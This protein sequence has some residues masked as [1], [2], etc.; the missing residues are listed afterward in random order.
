MAL[1]LED[2]SLHIELGSTFLQALCEIR[3]IIDHLIGEGVARRLLFPTNGNK[4]TQSQ[5]RLRDSG[6]ERRFV[7]I[8]L[9]VDRCTP[10]QVGREPA[11]IAEHG[12]QNSQATE[13]VTPK[14]LPG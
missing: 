10:N 8:D 9:L 7:F 12:S 2:N 14:R 6:K 1:A 4:H 3:G 11:R 5:V 13:R